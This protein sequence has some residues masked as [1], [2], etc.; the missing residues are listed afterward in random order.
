[1]VGV[2]GDLDGEVATAAMIADI[3]TKGMAR[4]LFVELL[5]LLDDYVKRASVSDAPRVCAG[6]E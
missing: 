1:M 6:A 4:A 2:G 3:L 5:Q